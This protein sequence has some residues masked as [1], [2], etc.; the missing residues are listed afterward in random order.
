MHLLQKL[1]PPWLL[2]LALLSQMTQSLRCLK[3]DH[4]ASRSELGH[5][6]AVNLL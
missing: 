1:T 5:K 3:K 4:R 6:P 2:C